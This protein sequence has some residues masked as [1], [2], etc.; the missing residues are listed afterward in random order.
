LEYEGVGS[1]S[2]TIVY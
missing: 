2:C 1:A